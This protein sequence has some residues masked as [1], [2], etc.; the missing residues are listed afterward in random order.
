MA[1]PRP[2][3]SW[4]VMAMAMVVVVLA[5]G[6]VTGAR[7]QL[8]MGFYAKSCPGVEKMVGDFVRQHVVRVPT[9]AAAL[10]RLHFHDCFVRGCDASVLLNSTAAGVAEKD[11][12]PN[13]TL[14]GFDFVDRVKTLVEEACPGVVSCA[15]VLALTARD[16]VA[17]IGGPSWRVPTGRRDG[18]VSSMQEALDEIPKPSMSFKELTDL[19]A[20]KGLG[21][22]D[23]VWLSGAHT[24]GIAHCSSFADRLYGHPAAGAG[25]D[26]TD[27]TLDAAYAANLRRR[28]CLAP[29]GGYAEDAVVEMDPGSHLTFDLGYYRALVKHRCLLQSD[30]ALLTDAAARA[31]VEGVVGGPDEV[32]FQL[33]ARS[34][35]TLGTVQVKT[36]AQGEIRRN[37]AVVNSPSN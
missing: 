17:A 28:K 19:F 20:T 26:T 34:M 30:A 13:L 18:T 5:G 4:S 35:A 25:N 31:D 9:V 11:A 8:R 14:R 23:L 29:N 6:A 2:R 15:D 22:R 24:I 36:G 37:C 3:S 16:A 33:F 1:T 27:P 21:V 12:P 7:A 10:L 32:F